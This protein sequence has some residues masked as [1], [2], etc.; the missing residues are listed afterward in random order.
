MPYLLG[1]LA[2][3]DIKGR[4][5]VHSVS[6]QFRGYAVR[7]AIAARLLGFGYDVINTTKAILFVA[8]ALLLLPGVM[9]QREGLRR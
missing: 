1:T 5:V 3:F 2:D 4:I 6:M 9:A 8:A 7:P